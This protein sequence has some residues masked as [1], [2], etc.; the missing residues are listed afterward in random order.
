MTIPEPMDLLKRIPRETSVLTSAA[1][2]IMT[3][4]G[5]I[6]N[7]KVLLHQSSLVTRAICDMFTTREFLDNLG[8]VRSG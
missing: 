6:V 1:S 7:L 4:V 8:K 5:L 3:K 2:W